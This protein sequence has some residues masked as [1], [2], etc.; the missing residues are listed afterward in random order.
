MLDGANAWGRWLAVAGGALLWSSTLLARAAAPTCG[1]SVVEPP[2]VCD[3]PGSSAPTCNCCS[4]TG[5][6]GCSSAGCTT[7]VC[8]LEPHCC[9]VGWDAVCTNLAAETPG[10][11]CCK[12]VCGPN[13]TLCG[14]GT[15]EPPE[16]CDPPGAAG[17]S[18]CCTAH[19]G[20][21]CSDPLCVTAICGF[22]PYCCSV[23]WDAICAGEALAEPTCEACAPAG[24]CDAVCCLDSDADGMC[25]SVDPCPLGD[26]LFD[27]TLYATTKTQFGWRFPANVDCVQGHLDLVGAY[28]VIDF[29]SSGAT[30]VVAAPELPAPGHGLYWLVRDDCNPTT[31]STSEPGECYGRPN[32]AAGGRDG[33][34]PPP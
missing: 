9:T 18:N 17:A 23:E 26:G 19:P 10:C 8:L 25:D 3:P 21:S 13:C 12:T 20:V 16:T 33:N 7:A 1:N 15:I 6:P 28:D 11:A 14:N 27:Q 4:A 24:V 32:C 31:W 5:G 22:D 2:E 34:L 30:N 29:F